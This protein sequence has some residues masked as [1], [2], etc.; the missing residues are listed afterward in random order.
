MVFQMAAAILLGLFLGRW[1]DGQFGTEPILL[2]VGTLFG[3]FSGLY[4]SLKDFL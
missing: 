2:V 1:L 3:V 4:L